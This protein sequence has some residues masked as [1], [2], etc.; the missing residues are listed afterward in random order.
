MIIFK[1]KDSPFVFMIGKE[2][3]KKNKFGLSE[4]FEQIG[5]WVYIDDEQCLAISHF[6]GGC[7]AF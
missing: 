5:W 2:N 4:Q 7:K 3:K 6:V 1:I